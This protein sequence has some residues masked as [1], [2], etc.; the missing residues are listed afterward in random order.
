[1]G[2]EERKNER[3]LERKANLKRDGEH[4]VLSLKWNYVPH[5]KHDSIIFVGFDSVATRLKNI[6]G[7][8]STQIATPGHIKQKQPTNQTARTN[9]QWAHIGF[10]I[11]DWI[12][13]EE[14]TNEKIKVR[15]INLTK[16]LSLHNMEATPVVAVLHHIDPYFSSDFHTF[17]MAAIKIAACRN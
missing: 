2:K 13:I 16:M 10:E 3:N 7:F 11:I 17:T 5:T 15:N 12:W 8:S 4:G 6:F 9:T 1:M 14:R